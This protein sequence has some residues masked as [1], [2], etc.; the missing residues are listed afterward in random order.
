MTE[1]EKMLYFAQKH[2]WGESAYV[3]GGVLHVQGHVYI[4][5]ENRSVYEWKRFTNLRELKEWAGY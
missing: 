5:H 2:D 3:R 4:P 1:L